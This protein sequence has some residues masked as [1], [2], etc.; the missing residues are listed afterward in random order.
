[1]TRARTKRARTTNGEATRGAPFDVET[2]GRVDKHGFKRM[3]TEDL[4]LTPAAGTH[5]GAAQARPDHAGARGIANLGNTCYMGAA[6]QAM[7]SNRSFVEGIREILPLVAVRDAHGSLPLSRSVVRMADALVHTGSS[8]VCPTGVKEALFATHPVFAETGQHDAYE[9][10]NSCLSA[11]ADEAGSDIRA[12]PVHRNFVLAERAVRFCGSCGEASEPRVQ[13][14]QGITLTFP[15]DIEI[16][17]TGSA[18]G[19]EA[20]TGPR[21]SLQDLMRQYYEPEHISAMC[22]SG[23]CDKSDAT[24]SLSLALAPHTLVLH[25]NRVRIQPSDPHVVSPATTAK[26]CEAVQIPEYIDTSAC[27]GAGALGSSV[28][29][30]SVLSMPADRQGRSRAISPRGTNVYRRR[31]R[32][33]PSPGA[34]TVAGLADAGVGSDGDGDTGA[35]GQGVGVDECPGKSGLRRPAHA[36]EN[37]AMIDVQRSELHRRQIVQI[38]EDATDE[39]AAACPAPSTYRLS[40][41]IRHRSASVGEGHYMCDVR[42]EDGTWSSFDDANATEGVKRPFELE[43]RMC[44]G[45]IFFFSA[46]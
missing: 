22:A 43:D 25:L 2:G 8:P 30:D 41:I 7:L 38:L 39:M 36:A 5:P 11:L 13:P 34:E 46:V 20:V 44:E 27:L 28:L 23:A 19:V 29:D 12:C 1:M 26:I 17:G 37:D 35:G 3:R 10:L 6:L 31:R 21:H 45:V 15:H 4:S 40:A 9:F 14:S 16:A 33:D 18:Q 32:S 42:R 24:Q